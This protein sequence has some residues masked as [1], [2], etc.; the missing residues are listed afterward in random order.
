MAQRRT[1]RASLVRLVLAYLLVVQAVLG[2]AVTGLHAAPSLAAGT[3]VLCTGGASGPFDTPDTHDAL[4]CVI[5]CAGA[6]QPLVAPGGAAFAPPTPRIQSVRFESA[7][8]AAAPRL[9]RSAF[10]ATGPPAR[11]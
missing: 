2:G 4:C 3:G 7:A 10:D 5:G 8:R 11:A 1:L 9:R 6:L